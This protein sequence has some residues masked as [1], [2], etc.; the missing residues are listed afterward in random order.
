MSNERIDLKQFEGIGEWK[1]LAHRHNKV[2]DWQVKT[3]RNMRSKEEAE[4]IAKLPSLIAEL[5]RCYERLD[6]QKRQFS[7][8]FELC[9]EYIDPRDVSEMTIQQGR[10]LAEIWS[11]ASYAKDEKELP[12][13]TSS[14]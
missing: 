2:I 5:K 13:F 6:A 11:M 10:I 7:E 4:T 8:I 1:V 9:S 12:D 14:E 3:G